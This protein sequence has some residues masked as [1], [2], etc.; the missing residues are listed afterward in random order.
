MSDLY[1][2]VGNPVAHSKSPLIHAEFARQTG[3][4]VEY[5]RLLAPLDGF[6][7]ALRAFRA[8]GGC[9]ANI[10]IPFKEQAFA[11]A[12]QPSPRALLAGAVNTIRFDDEGIFGDNTDGV[13][14]VRDIE[15]NLG[16]SLAA[17]RVLVLGAGGAARGILGAIADCRPAAIT[18]ANRDLA[19]AARVA[20]ALASVATIEVSSYVELRGSVNDIIINATASSIHHECP[21]LPGGVFAE[22]ALAYDL[23]YAA[24]PT[25]FMLFA[26]TQMAA[27]VADGKGMLVEQAAESF[28]V[29]RGVR[30]S[31]APVIAMLR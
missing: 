28:F 1:A 23:M 18:L 6:A 11:L 24:E 21:P 22:H 26:K 19:K 4:Q 7:A 12:T 13:G 2:V 17:K 30:P 3:E 10:T 29:W 5:R 16:C 25:P 14:L 15:H 20:A 31:T 9:G 27:T 8:E